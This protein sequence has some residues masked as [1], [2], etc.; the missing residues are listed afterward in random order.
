MV[1]VNKALWLVSAV[2]S[3]GVLLYVFA[4]LPE[5]VNYLEGTG[6]SI[7]RDTFFYAS[8]VL[9]AVI[10]TLFYAFAGKLSKGKKWSAPLLVYLAN[11]HYSFAV[12]INTFICASLYF[13]SIFNS[14]E[15]LNYN[16]VGYPI[17]VALALMAIW[18]L[19]LP[20]IFLSKKTVS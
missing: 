8:L 19:A 9:L 13:L 20:F 6:N 5:Q 17:Y 1:R 14:G 12:L 7:G 10:N 11:W 4:G 2:A 15:H 18:I 16:N 3:L